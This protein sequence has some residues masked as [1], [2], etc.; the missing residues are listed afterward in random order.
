MFNKKK[1]ILA[2]MIVCGLPLWL[3]LAQQKAIASHDNTIVTTKDY[4]SVAEAIPIETKSSIEQKPIT[5]ALRKGD[6]AFDYMRLGLTKEGAEIL[7]AK[8][9][10]RML[11]IS[12]YSN[13][14]DRKM[15]EEALAFQKSSDH[16]DLTEE[17]AK[18]L[19]E[20]DKRII[21]G[22]PDRD[23]LSFS[24]SEIPNNW[25]EY[26]Y[27]GYA[28]DDNKD[29]Y[30]EGYKLPMVRRIYERADGN[31]LI[32]DEETLND[33]AEIATAEFITDK[34]QGYPAHIHSLLS[35]ETN[36]QATYLK[37]AT[38][39]SQYVMYI[40]GDNMQYNESKKT[41]INLA[42]EI[43]KNNSVVK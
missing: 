23:S 38:K 14:E 1:N 29:L 18:D 11:S 16:L 39:N 31:R 27:I 3:Y 41:L 7:E 22:T 32:I 30:P 24:P 33:G 20:I 28:E 21:K 17:V 6:S 10:K 12:H 34:I 13:P 26:N 19:Y 37:V 2:G 5:S 40:I 15:L 35:P 43:I 42:E 25:G 4:L 9:P 8:D 36:R